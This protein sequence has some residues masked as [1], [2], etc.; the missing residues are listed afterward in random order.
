MNTPHDLIQNSE[1]ISQAY[2]QYHQIGLFLGAGV[3]IDSEVPNYDKLVVKLV[4]EIQKKGQ[5]SN[6]VDKK[7]LQLLLSL[8]LKSSEENFEIRSKPEE[9]AQFIES[10]FI[11]G[12]GQALEQS[13]REILYQ[14][15]NTNK[16]STVY[17]SNKTLNAIITFCVELLNPNESPSADSIRP[18]SKIG[19]ILTT[20][21]DNLVEACCHSKFNK[22]NLIRPIGRSSTQEYKIKS[23]NTNRY[24]GKLAIPMYHIHGY[25]HYKKNID[26][27]KIVIAEEDYYATSYDPLSFCNYVSMSALRKYPFIFIGSKMEDHNIRRFLYHLRTENEEESIKHFAILQ[28][29]DDPGVI[30]Y[31]EAILDKAFNVIPI[32]IKSYDKIP[33]VLKMVY[34]GNNNKKKNE[35]KL[36][37][38]YEK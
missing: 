35:W 15:V 20:N 11:Q 22:R 23:K 31:Q 36:L 24:R 27:G 25:I 16:F 13:V 17:N 32:W 37:L 7:A 21:Y 38:E 10:F 14:D 29:P 12:K 34:C 4:Q 3:T 33:E 9:I 28:R 19:T 8:P 26:P 30:S 5:F 2:K 1:K 18:N 6:K